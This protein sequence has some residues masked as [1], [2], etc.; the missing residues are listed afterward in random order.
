[1]FLDEHC[2]CDGL[3][4]PTGASCHQVNAILDVVHVASIQ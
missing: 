4:D 2:D 1:M 3:P